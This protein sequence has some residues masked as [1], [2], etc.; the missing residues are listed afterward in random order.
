MRQREIL[1]NTD[2]SRAA[3]AHSQESKHR[4]RDYDIRFLIVTAR[5]VIR[6]YRARSDFAI[7]RESAYYFRRVSHRLLAARN[8]RDL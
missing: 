5:R 2:I 7:F 8:E 6:L 4:D 3:L 1:F